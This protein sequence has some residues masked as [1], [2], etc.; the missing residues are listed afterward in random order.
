MKTLFE[1]TKDG[2]AA[3]ATE[4]CELAAAL[5]FMNEKKRQGYTATF[6]ERTNHKKFIV[7]TWRIE[8]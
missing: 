1:T 4:F 8:K 7:Y 2:T 6:P 3:R 5:R